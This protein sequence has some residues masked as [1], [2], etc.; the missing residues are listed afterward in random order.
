MNQLN[1]AAWVAGV[2]EGVCDASGMHADVSAHNLGT[3][4][5]PGRTVFLVKFREETGAREK[6]LDRM[7]VK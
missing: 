2:V 6:E 3:D 1:C 4:M 7:G 5:W